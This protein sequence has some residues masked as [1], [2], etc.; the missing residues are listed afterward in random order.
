MKALVSTI[1]LIIIPA[2]LLTMTGT[3]LT[4]YLLVLVIMNLMGIMSVIGGS[5]REK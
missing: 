5:K 1:D 2:Y 4:N 3:E